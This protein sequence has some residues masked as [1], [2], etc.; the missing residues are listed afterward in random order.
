MFVPVVY[1][2]LWVSQPNGQLEVD[3]RGDDQPNRFR[4]FALSTDGAFYTTDIKGITRRPTT[5]APG[6]PRPARSPPCTPPTSRRSRRRRHRLRVATGDGGTVTDDGSS[7]PPRT[8]SSSPTTTAAAGAGRR[9]CC[10]VVRAC[11]DS[12][13][14]APS[15]AS[16]GLRHL[17]QLSSRPCAVASHRSPDGGASFIDHSRSAYQLDGVDPHGLEILAVDPRNA[18]VVWA[19]AARARCPK[20]MSTTVDLP[21]PAPL[22]RTAASAGPSFYKA[23]FGHRGFGR[24]RAA[25][26]TSPSTSRKKRVYVA[27]R[28]GVLAGSDD[29]SA[30]APVLAPTGP[31]D[32]IA[33]RRRA[34]RQA[35]NVCTS[36]FQA[37]LRR[38]R[39]VDR[40]RRQPTA[41]VLNY[42]DTLGPVDCPA[43][44]PV[45][46]LCPSYW[47]MYGAQ[48][49][50]EFDGGVP[51]DLTTMMPP[52]GVDCSCSVG[53]ASSAVG[54]LGF[55]ALLL[56]LGVRTVARSGGRARR[57]D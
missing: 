55:A 13:R 21:R 36:Q 4:K 50:I 35:F 44:T 10:A 52:K 8:G 25:S 3:L 49:G 57:R 2:G 23:R 16:G 39:A 14:V 48:L 32:H 1:W 27:T 40:Q 46:D 53:A 17:E 28:T 22:H 37:R 24:R 26:T 18:D 19:R 45:G 33:V 29:G 56:V 31:L 43:G 30:T 38:G 54:G 5:A 47:Y 11:F 9:P 20:G 7:S 15:S 41:S 6:P 34:R 42:V 51:G 12:V